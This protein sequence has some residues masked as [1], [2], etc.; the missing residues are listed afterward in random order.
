[1]PDTQEKSTM[2][3]M[4]VAPDDRPRTLPPAAPHRPRRGMLWLLLILAAGG[5][6]AWWWWS[7]KP[8][9]GDAASAVPTARKKF[10]PASRPVPVQIAK[11]RTQ[12]LDIH[13]SG[14]GTVTPRNVVAVKSR[15]DGELVKV[16]FTEGQLVEKGE[17]LAMIDPRPFQVQFTQAE[18]QLMRDKALLKNAELDL[19]RYRKL[20]AE[21]S[22]A[23]QQV[24]T[25]VSLVEQYRGT[26]ESDR[27]QLDNAR[28]QLAYCRVVAPIAGR[29]GL[30]LVDAGNI[31]HASD[32][33]GIVT[34]TQVSPTTVVFTLPEDELP[35]VVRQLRASRNLVA[36]AWDRA[37]RQK[38]ATGTLLTIDNQIDTT[39]GTVK[40]KA[41][42]ANEDATLFPNQFVNVQLLV[43]TRVN[44][45]VVPTAAIQRGT[46]GAFVY[47]MNDDRTVAV[48]PVKMGPTEGET[49][50]VESGLTP[51]DTVV[52][53]GADKLREG[54]KVEPTERG[55]GLATPAVPAV[56]RDGSRRWGAGRDQGAGP[57]GGP[58]PPG[59]PG[60]DGGVPT[61]NGAK[62]AGPADTA[63][64]RTLAGV[65]ASTGGEGPAASHR[66]HASSGPG[67]AGDAGA[68]AAPA[69]HRAAPAGDAAPTSAEQSAP[70][71]KPRRHRRDKTPADE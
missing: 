46:Q 68:A 25:Q 37:G 14:L 23:S 2:E 24:D 44:A 57:T 5:G 17:L 61:R 54:A 1:M 65:D 60:P 64:G 31:V 70:D 49:T 20:L 4:R 55:A 53:D 7:G 47:L 6:G 50:I 32:S 58:R 29:V 34:I 27:G 42:F 21:D 43:D 39:T 71:A 11:A 51:G 67:D 19:A 12:S 16:N 52:S 41:E 59:A 33:T 13:L 22:I 56:G 48:R 9:G 8:A 10:D 26:V 66:R 35:K 36:E 45:V 63:P 3:D 69:P 28:L 30:R 40:L 62:G 18:G 38:L 15:V